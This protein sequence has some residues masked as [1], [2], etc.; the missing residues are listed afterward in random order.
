M[1]IKYKPFALAILF[2]IST[3]LVSGCAP[4]EVN[5]DEI[6]SMIDEAQRT[7]NMADYKAS[8]AKEMA[9]EALTKLQMMHMKKGHRKMKMMMK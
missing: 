8:Q 3:A 5:L 4:K 9:D 7:A 1:Y 6:R 2:A